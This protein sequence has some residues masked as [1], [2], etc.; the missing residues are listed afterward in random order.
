MPSNVNNYFERIG[1]NILS[2]LDGKHTNMSAR[3]VGSFSGFG[4]KNEFTSIIIDVISVL[5]G[6]P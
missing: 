5:V 4:K 6:A 2:N 3:T 1:P